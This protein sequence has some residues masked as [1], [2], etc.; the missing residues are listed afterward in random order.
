MPCAVIDT[1]GSRLQLRARRLE[2]LGPTVP[3]AAPAPATIIPIHGLDHVVLHEH[4]QATTQAL[5]ALLREGIPIHLVSESGRHLGSCE[6]SVRPSAGTRLLQYRQTMD[7]A[8]SLGIARALVAAKLANQRRILVRS[9][10]NRPRPLDSVLAAL[11]DRESQAVVAPDVETLR[12][13]EGAGSAVYFSAWASFFPAEFPF[14][15]R[16][17]RPP[18]NAVNAC[19]GFGAA[20][21]AA[22]LVSALHRAG[23]DPGLGALHAT[24]DGRCALALDIIEP[25][26]PAIVEAFTMRLFSHRMLGAED[27]EAR[28]GGVFLNHQGRQTFLEHYQTR[29]VREFYSDHLGHRTTVRRLFQA[30][31]NDIKT[32]LTEPE[33]YR[34]FRL[35]A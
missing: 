6:P 3:D 12:G 32:A 19:L 9:A 1:P 35:N 26:R 29:L 23:L 13:I 4:A 7:A 34:P 24:Q 33:I 10:K 17:T 22:E 2:I 16:S 11:A 8:W 5:G 20:L 18:L 15:R 31:A 25:F 21:V 14:K 27:F 30:A 28:D